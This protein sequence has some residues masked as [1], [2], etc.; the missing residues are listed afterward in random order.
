[1][2]HNYQRNQN[3]YEM[4]LRMAQEHTP[5]LHF[6]GT[7]AGEFA[8]WKAELVPKVAECLGAFPA[9]VP[10]NP[11]LTARWEDNGLIRERWMIDVQEHLSASLLLVKG[12]RL[13]T[14]FY[15]AVQQLMLVFC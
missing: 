8:A 10:L 4:F 11:A 12:I 9:K 15:P 7:T 2:T 1:M 5:E 6:T 14:K 13:I 3:P